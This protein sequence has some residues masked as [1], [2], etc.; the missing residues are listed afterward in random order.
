MTTFTIL[1]INYKLLLKKLSSR[2]LAVGKSNQKTMKAPQ[3]IALHSDGKEGRA[4]DVNE[5]LVIGRDKVCDIRVKA[6]CI[7][8]Q[9]ARISVD[10]NGKVGRSLHIQLYIFITFIIDVSV[11]LCSPLFD[12]S[13]A[14]QWRSDQ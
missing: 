10:E 12:E 1:L 14:D 4:F 7:S 9:H 5:T 2:S 11:M 3:L 13:I 6:A 8:R